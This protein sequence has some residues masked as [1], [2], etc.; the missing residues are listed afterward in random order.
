MNFILYLLAPLF[1]SRANVLEFCLL[2][3]FKGLRQTNQNSAHK[4]RIILR[5][6]V[7]GFS[8]RPRAN[9]AWQPELA[10]TP[11]L[12]VS[13]TWAPRAT[14]EAMFCLHTRMPPGENRNLPARR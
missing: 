3:L 5:H 8:A 4:R 10:G 14:V 13:V 12:S 2:S 11:A 7:H 6:R 1:K 9:T